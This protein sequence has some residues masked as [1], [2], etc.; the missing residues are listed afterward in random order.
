MLPFFLIMASFLGSPLAPVSVSNDLETLAGARIL[1]SASPG[2]ARVVSR[3]RLPTLGKTNRERGR[4]F[5]ARYGALTGG[6]ALRFESESTSKARTV[7]RY[8][9][10]HNNVV[11]LNRS[12]TVTVDGEGHIIAFNSDCVPITEAAPQVVDEQAARD[13]ASKA[14]QAKYG[15]KPTGLKAIDAGFGL[16]ANGSYVVPVFEFH[17]APLPMLSHVKVRIDASTGALLSIRNTLIH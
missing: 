13:A 7:L 17:I 11:I 10:W 1:W 8:R 5:L 16:M 4:H 14:I 12:A 15:S 6:A 3:I 9:Q 2:Q